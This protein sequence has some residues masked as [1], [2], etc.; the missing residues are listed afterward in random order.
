MSD[1]SQTA[2]TT[3]PDGSVHARYLIPLWTWLAI[4]TVSIAVFFH[5]ASQGSPI[6]I[7]FGIKVANDEIQKNLAGT[8]G[9][10]FLAPSLLALYTLT[11]SWMRRLQDEKMPASRW[12]WL[13]AATFWQLPSGDPVARVLRLG[14]WI[15]VLALCP[16]SLGH[17]AKKHFDA[18]FYQECKRLQE[19]DLD[20]CKV[21]E[22]N[23]LVT[24]ATDATKKEAYRTYATQRHRWESF[25][26]HLS[27]VYLSAPDY[28][29]HAFYL[30]R[31][32]GNTYFPGLQGWAYLGLIAMVVWQWLRILVSLVLGRVVLSGPWSTLRRLALL[33][34]P[35]R[36]T[37]PITPPQLGKPMV[38][39][40]VIGHRKITGNE[41]GLRKS[42]QTLLQQCKREGYG[43]RVVCGMAEGAD[44]LAVDVVLTMIDADDAVEL[45]VVLP[46]EK[47]AFCAHMQASAP[48]RAAHPR[49]AGRVGSAT[50]PAGHSRE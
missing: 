50:G 27:L 5:A 22:N 4:L 6:W 13:P 1:S 21:W 42:L 45:L 31:P 29:D 20:G 14:L 24:D 43:L 38:R 25:R 47:A 34:L 19:K 16:F 28:F 49:L 46:G 40:G 33:R 35:E 32:S 39:V 36:N 11:L 10:I 7:E 48:S 41:E 18:P 9:V 44:R 30:G 23:S 26:T 17:L 3:L 37:D 8:W 2:P 15:L 12:E